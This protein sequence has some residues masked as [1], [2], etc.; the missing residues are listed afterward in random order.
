M[1]P[2]EHANEAGDDGVGEDAEG[3]LRPLPDPGGRRAQVVHEPV[4]S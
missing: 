1:F 4:A 2:H 3:V